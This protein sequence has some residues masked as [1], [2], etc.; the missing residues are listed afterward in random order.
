LTGFGDDRLSQA[1]QSRDFGG[2]QFPAVLPTCDAARGA[3]VSFHKHTLALIQGTAK[4]RFPAL[5]RRSLAFSIQRREKTRAV[6]DVGLRMS[7]DKK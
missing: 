3:F 2:D 5:A 7:G 6:A 4:L 1:Y